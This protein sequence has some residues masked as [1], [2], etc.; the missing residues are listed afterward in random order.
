LSYAET[1]VAENMP[2]RDSIPAMVD[3]Q[4]RAAQAHGCAF[5][6]TYQWMG[7][8]GSS[9]TW[10][11]RGLVGRDFQHPTSEGAERIGAA[12]FAGLVH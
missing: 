9:L 12:L 10:N 8:K 3:A 5:W 4:H 6:D 11:K 2:P 7:G 1:S